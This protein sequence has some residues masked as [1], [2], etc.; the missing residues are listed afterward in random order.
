MDY[1]TW[2][3]AHLDRVLDSK[4]ISNQSIIW[5]PLSARVLNLQSQDPPH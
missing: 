5:K 3:E 1:G 2:E 4:K